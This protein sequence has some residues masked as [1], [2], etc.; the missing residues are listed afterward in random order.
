MPCPLFLPGLLLPLSDMYAGEC[1][2]DCEAPLSIE[3]L[4]RCCNPGYA[5]NRCTSAAT[6]EADSHRFL[7]CSD[8]GGTIEIAWASE[9]DHHP[10]AVGKLRFNHALPAAA[11]PLEHQ[12]RA[13]AQNYLHQTGC[14]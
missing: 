10:I 1:S 12:A 7:V 6:A 9:R 5:R 8:D 14:L 3:K 2:A 13:C 4:T 11:G